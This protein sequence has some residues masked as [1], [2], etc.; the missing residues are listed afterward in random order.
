MLDWQPNPVQI[1]ILVD[2]ITRF[3]HLPDLA[4]PS[5]SGDQP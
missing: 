5:L 2:T 3:A 1:A 4:G